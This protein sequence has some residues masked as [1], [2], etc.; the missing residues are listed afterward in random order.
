MCVDF[1]MLQQLYVSS[2]V[3]ERVWWKGAVTQVDRNRIPTVFRI[4]EHG[5]SI[6]GHPVGGLITVW[7]LPAQC[8]FLACHWGRDPCQLDVLAAPLLSFKIT[9]KCGAAV[10]ERKDALLSSK[11]TTSFYQVF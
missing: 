3:E 2:T 6:T 10:I 7:K 9:R 8:R 1:L 5:G 4:T 11:S